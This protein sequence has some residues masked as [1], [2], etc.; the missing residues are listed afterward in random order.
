M[1]P[2]YEP[3]F[4]HSL[5]SRA[6]YRGDEKGGRESGHTRQ[7]GGRES[8]QT[9][10]ADDPKLNC[11]TP[12]TIANKLLRSKYRLYAIRYIHERFGRAK[13]THLA[14][15]GKRTRAREGGQRRPPKA[16]RTST[17]GIRVGSHTVEPLPKGRGATAAT[18]RT[19][20]SSSKAD[21][22][23][24]DPILMRRPSFQA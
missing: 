19:T 4:S 13:S 2:V 14:S 15:Q 24:N 20:T 1:P 16:G 5:L 22:A 17:R 10:G 21:V 3:T 8:G 23:T 18:A 7:E 11:S 12:N 6:L 9:T